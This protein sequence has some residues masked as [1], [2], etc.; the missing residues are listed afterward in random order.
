MNSDD[1]IYNFL[2]EQ[3]FER[4]SDPIYEEGYL[5][6]NHYALHIPMIILTLFPKNFAMRE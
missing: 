4:L 1:A 5:A 3:H 2:L 6:E